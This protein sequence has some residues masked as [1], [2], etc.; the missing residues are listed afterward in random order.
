MNLMIDMNSS[1]GMQIFFS[2][3]VHLFVMLRTARFREMFVNSEVASKE[4]NMSSLCIVLF[5]RDLC[6][7]KLLFTCLLLC[8]RLFKMMLCINLAIA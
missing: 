1:K 6:N 3:S 7:S 2:M 8:V 5:E 4:S